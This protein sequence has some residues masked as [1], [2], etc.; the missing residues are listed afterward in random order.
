MTFNVLTPLGSILAGSFLFRIPPAPLPRGDRDA[1]FGS[2]LLPPFSSLFWAPS[3]NSVL[4]EQN[5]GSLPYT[6]IAWKKY[7]RGSTQ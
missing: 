2:H 3:T 1:S 7:S 5:R 6:T 4:P